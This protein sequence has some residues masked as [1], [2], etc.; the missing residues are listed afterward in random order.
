MSRYFV[1]KRPEKNK[2]RLVFDA[3]AKYCGISL[4]SALYQGPDLTNGLRGVLL[5]FRE[6][7]VA[8]GGDIESMFCA[9]RVPP[10]QR[11][12]L[13]FFWYDDN[14]H[15]KGVAVYRA[16]SHIFGCTS[17]PAVASYGLN[18]VLLVL[19]LTLLL[20]L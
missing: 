7:P 3:S 1:L 20:L 18:F 13:R 2:V 14:D 12:F 11:N 9:F 4:N 17:S 6:R 10:E 19:N 8:F 15:N 16:S 5:R